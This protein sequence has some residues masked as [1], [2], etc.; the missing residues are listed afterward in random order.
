MGVVSLQP[1]IIMA[2]LESKTF[3]DQTS[4]ARDASKMLSSAELISGKVSYLQ[5]EFT[6]PAGVASGDFIRLC[7]IPSGMTII[8]DFCKVRIVNGT[9]SAGAV[10]GSFFVTKESETTPVVS[11]S[12][13][14]DIQSGSRFFDE[15]VF[16]AVNEK[17]TERSILDLEVEADVDEGSQMIFNLFLVN[18]N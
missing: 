3:T 11:I 5:A 15:G 1:T 9:G 12:D 13:S 18:S 8:P 6:A 14:L 7:Y 4:A 16:A 2:I 17:T 10:N